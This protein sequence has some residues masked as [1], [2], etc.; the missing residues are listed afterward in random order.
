MFESL[1]CCPSLGTS[2]TD[3][4]KHLRE[5]FP[6]IPE[7]NLRFVYTL[8]KED[9]CLTS[10]CIL[11]GPSLES[12]LP[13]LR[14]ARISDESSG[15]KLQINQDEEEGDE[16]V[17]RVFAFYKGVKFDSKA[18]IRF[19]LKSQPAVDAGGVRRQVFAK[20]LKTVAFSDKL[21]LFE[22]PPNRRRT[23]FRISN[24]SS[25]MMKLLGCIVGHSIV[26]G[27]QGFPYLSPI[28]LQ[29]HDWKF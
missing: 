19:S 20:V 28:L 26:L 24:L 10:D 3:E 17:E 21:R 5:M 25:G 29:L 14:A 15:C 6:D 2:T 22:G 16:L 13:L 9:V 23:V 18:E 1:S 12:P 7:Q 8:S 27:H 4:Y 11:T